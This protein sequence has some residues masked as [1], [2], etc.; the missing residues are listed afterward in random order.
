M[1][2]WGV[3]GEGDSGGDNGRGEKEEMGFPCGQKQT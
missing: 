3:R 1:L 2:S